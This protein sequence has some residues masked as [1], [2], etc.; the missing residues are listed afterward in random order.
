[1]MTTVTYEIFRQWR[2]QWGYK[3]IYTP[4]NVT[5]CTSKGQFPCWYHRLW[6][7]KIIL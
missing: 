1:M 3:E 5:H 2:T 6:Q 7:A 4:K